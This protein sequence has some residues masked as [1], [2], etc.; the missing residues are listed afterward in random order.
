MKRFTRISALLVSLEDHIFGGDIEYKKIYN[1]Q[2]KRHNIVRPY[3][4]MAYFLI[5][6][7]YSNL[8]FR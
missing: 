3:C 8:Q 5:N 6:Q 1:F 2:L 4:Q 7:I